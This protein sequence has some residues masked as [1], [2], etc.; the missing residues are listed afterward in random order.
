VT[1]LGIG[2][3]IASVLALVAGI[4]GDLPELVAVGLAG[5]AAI[6][7]AGLWMLVRPDLLAVR[8]IV[9]PRVAQD[10]AAKALLLVQNLSNRRSPPI[11]ASDAVGSTRV[12]VPVPS[13]AAGAA[14][15]T[16][17]PL[18]TGRRGIFPVGPFSVGHTDPLRL[19]AVE[20]THATEAVLIVH[21]RI[22][23]V[24]PLPTGLTRDAEGPTSA[25][26]PRGGIAFHSMRPYEPGDPIRDIHWKKSAQTGQLMVSH[27]V[28][29]DEP[30]LLLLLDT[31]TASYPHGGFEDAVRAAASLASAAIFGGYPLELRTSAGAIAIFEGG[32]AASDASADILD[33]LAGAELGNDDPGLH[34]LLRISLTRA[35][36]SLGV[37]TGQPP[38]QG[39]A[40]VQ[41]VRPKF[42][43]ASA[44]Q[45][46]PGT[47]S[48]AVDLAGVFGVVC[49][50]SADFA[51]RWNDVLRR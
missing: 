19:M 36:V 29:P 11:L 7:Q 9:P 13:L 44:V 33:L 42:L 28:I 30:S 37:V 39:L 12:S 17:Y 20:R 25:S 35:A 18:P 23:D 26:S 51:R 48:P 10:E 21:P 4:L 47:S 5:A 46:H 15:T 49:R 24:A 8:E 2:I 32:R 43:M 1:R 40:V 50:D 22:H 14:H 38:A 6:L 31:S 45:I 27:K 34:A 41:L 3:A 16:S